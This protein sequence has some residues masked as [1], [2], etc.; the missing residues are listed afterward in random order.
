MLTPQ[1]LKVLRFIDVYVRQNEGVS[2]SY[3]EIKDHLGIA[4]KS[5]VNRIVTALKQ[6]GFLRHGLNLSR[7]L[8]V[9]RLPPS[10][11]PAAPAGERKRL[12]LSAISQHIAAQ[13]W[14]AADANTVRAAIAELTA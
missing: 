2:P 7:N 1:Q 9:L 11:G 12:G 4:S 6:R 3:D 13:P 10:V 14:C 8:E 5:G